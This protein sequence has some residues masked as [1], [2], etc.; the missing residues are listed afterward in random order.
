MLHSFQDLLDTCSG[1]RQDSND[2]Q[3][4]W[5]L[6]NALQP[7]FHITAAVRT[8]LQHLRGAS[9]AMMGLYAEHD[10]ARFK[11]LFRHKQVS[12]AQRIDAVLVH[13]SAA[14]QTF[15]ATVSSAN[16]RVISLHQAAAM[17]DYSQA[18]CDLCMWLLFT[19]AGCCRW[20]N[21]M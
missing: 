16:L 19:M 8:I 11:E 14:N 5:K 4:F 12:N 6:L 20:I 3:L 1:L 21:H 2:W 10:T 15:A 17:R 9:F 13:G 18:C 7:A